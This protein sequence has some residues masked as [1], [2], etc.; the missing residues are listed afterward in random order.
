[1]GRGHYAESVLFVGMCL[2][3]GRRVGWE[4]IIRH[5]NCFSSKLLVTLIFHDHLRYC[6]IFLSRFLISFVF[7][8]AATIFLNR[9]SSL[10]MV[11][12][13]HIDICVVTKQVRDK[14]TRKVNKW[15]V[16]KATLRFS[17]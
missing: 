11:L 3:V 15:P 10:H 5:Q 1:M 6:E 8:K 2:F 13:P 7:N 9:I 4:G 12:F 17:L 16:T 14:T